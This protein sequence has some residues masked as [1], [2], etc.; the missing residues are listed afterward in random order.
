[1]SSTVTLHCAICNHDWQRE[2]Q[3]GRRPASCPDCIAGEAARVESERA[4]AE[5]A[6]R[7]WE[8]IAETAME[9]LG[10]F[11]RETDRKVEAALDRVIDTAGEQ[12]YVDVLADLI[13]DRPNVTDLS[14]DWSAA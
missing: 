9:R 3:R 12:W 5:P 8:R 4:S 1:M 13:R 7:N 14:P 2:S 10:T 11:G 6:T